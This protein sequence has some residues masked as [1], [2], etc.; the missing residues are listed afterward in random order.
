M[1]FLWSHSQEYKMCVRIDENGFGSSKVIY[2]H[3][4]YSVS[5]PCWR[6]RILFDHMNTRRFSVNYYF[7][8]GRMS[9]AKGVTMLPV[10]LLFVVIV[11]CVSFN[12]V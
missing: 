7:H 10:L 1:Q 3:S 9:K 4:K 11:Y 5:N 6:S 12:S 8:W 2:I